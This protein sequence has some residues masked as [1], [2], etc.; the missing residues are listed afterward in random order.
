MR[1]YT[2]I[3]YSQ[4]AIY[5]AHCVGFNKKVDQRSYMYSDAVMCILTY[6]HRY[7]V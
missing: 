2:C 5:S 6:Y 1:K 3:E 4:A 7:G